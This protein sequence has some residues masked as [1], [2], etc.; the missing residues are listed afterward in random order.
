MDAS[1]ESHSRLRDPTANTPLHVAPLQTIED[2]LPLRVTDLIINVKED[3]ND[4][5]DPVCELT[6]VLV[7]DILIKHK[8]LSGSSA[9]IPTAEGVQ[10]AY[11]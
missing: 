1:K 9:H 10:K 2:P 7:D 3:L 11:T 6:F 5:S 4:L 8:G